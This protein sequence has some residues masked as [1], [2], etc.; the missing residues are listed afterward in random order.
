[1]ISVRDAVLLPRPQRKTPILIGGNGPKRSLPLA[2]KYAD[3]WNGVFLDVDTYRA[4]NKRLDRI[5]GKERSRP[6]SRSNAR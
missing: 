6:A 5:A 2:A 3:E 4:R 1:M